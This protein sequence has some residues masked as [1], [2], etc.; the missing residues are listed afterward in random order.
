MTLLGLDAVTPSLPLLPL[1]PSAPVSF[2]LVAPLPSRVE[3]P[4][5]LLE[6][7]NCPSTFSAIVIIIIIIIITIIIFIS[8]PNV[9][10]EVYRISPDFNLFE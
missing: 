5:L 8:V 7:V 3:P 10:A 1:N 9:S 4:L 2:S 6:L